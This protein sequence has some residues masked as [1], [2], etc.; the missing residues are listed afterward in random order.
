MKTFQLTALVIITLLASCNNR[1]AE[2]EAQTKLSDY[3]KYV[4][5]QEYK[6]EQAPIT[7][8]TEVEV[9]ADLGGIPN[10]GDTVFYYQFL[11]KVKETGDTFRILCP[12]ITLEVPGGTNT[13]TAVTPRA[14]TNRKGVTTAYYELIDN[15]KSLLLNAENAE[16]MVA[17]NDTAYI[18]H[19]MN[20]ANAKEF[21]ILD[22]EAPPGDNLRFK[23]AVGTLNFKQVPW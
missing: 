3:Y 12:Q 7:P 5:L 9:L 21:V 4:P 13:K 16:K 19:L 23:T 18:N 20:P 10:I 2:T 14:Y 17:S 15:S 11:V 6:F 8:G 22:K 1:Q